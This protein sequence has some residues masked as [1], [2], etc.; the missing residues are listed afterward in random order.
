M[1][2]QKKK[3]IL[4][5]TVI[6]ALTGLG[7]GLSD[8][9]FPN[10]FKDA[11]NTDAFQRGL[12]EFPRETPG[13]ISVFVMSLLASLG[14]IR[15]SVLAQI[16]CIAGLTAL[17]FLTPDFGVML[18]FLFLFSMG[19]HIFM[20][21]TD[22]IGM[23]LAQDGG[24]GSVMGRFKG[25]YTAF[26]M[27][28]GILVFVGFKAGWFSFTSRV[29]S[30]F[31]LAAVIFAVIFVLLLYMWRITDKK[32]ARQRSRLI[33]RKEYGIFYLLSML[34]GAR[35]QIMLVYGPWVLID[36]LGFGV[37]TMAIL[38]IAGAAAGIFFM[39]AVGRW[40]DRYGTARIMIVE[41]AAFFLVYIAYGVLSS[42]LYL[43][44]L[45]AAG[46]PVAA[47]FAINMADRMT[48]QFGMVRSVYMRSVA[49]SPQEV[50]PTLSLGMSLDHVLSILSAILCGWLW[51]SLGPQ[52]VF[53][54][55]ALLSVGNMLVALGIRKE[56]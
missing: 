14:D 53:V 30:I 39:P 3:A 56:Q 25:V 27:V 34:F 11:Y 10:Y 16:L 15:I 52:Y 9:V 43:G 19:Q 40:I 7:M 17:G 18:I 2:T 46:M 36:L 38:A 50:T 4:I 47:A 55:A 21:L 45:A 54:F 35:K 41:A 44:W 32:T 23:S 37:D 48:I 33:I 1:D 24:Y 29:K 12:I 20:P 51:K 6:T 49:F 42:G 28:A 31:I 22:S 5:F 26:T 8:T 13:L